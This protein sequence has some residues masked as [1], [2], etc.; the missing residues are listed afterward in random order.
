MKP[1]NSQRK[2][3][4]EMCALILFFLSNMV[5]LYYSYLFV[6]VL[7][8][9]EVVSTIGRWFPVVQG[10]IRRTKRR[11]G[12]I[13]STV[14][15]GKISFDWW[16][17][18]FSK[19]VS[20]SHCP[21]IR[22]AQYL[23]RGTYKSKVWGMR[24]LRWKHEGWRPAMG[25]RIKTRRSSYRLKRSVP[26]GQRGRKAACAT[27]PHKGLVSFHGYFVPVF[28]YTPLPF[29]A[30]LLK[31]FHFDEIFLERRPT[32]LFSKTSQMVEISKNFW[33]PTRK[34]LIQHTQNIHCKNL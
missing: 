5:I 2:S 13:A 1:V 11:V 12:K 6:I 4:N 7:L 10:S 25:I 23:H 32:R 28:A 8:I 31:L 17:I 33:N 22:A 24:G 19:G 15:A 3:L 30:S 29:P 21:N 14:R 16:N 20:G 34:N 18:D 26:L 27:V 9:A